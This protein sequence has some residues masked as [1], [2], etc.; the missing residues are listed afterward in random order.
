MRTI[1]GT[2][3][4]FIACTLSAQ[5]GGQHTYA[6][7]DLDNSAR[8]AALGGNLISVQDND[9]NVAYF[10]PSLLNDEMNGEIGM[11]FVDYFAGTNFGYTSYAHHFDKLGTFSGTVQFVNYGKFQETDI[12]GNVLGEF[13]ASDYVLSIGYGRKLTGPFSIGANMK[14]IFSTLERYTSFGLAFDIAGTMHLEEK[15]FTAAAVIRNAGLMLKTYVTSVREPL[16]FEVQ[17]GISYKLKHAPIRFS[18]IGENL[19]RWDLTYVDPNAQ[20]TIDPLTGEEVPVKT[21]GFGDKLMRHIVIGTEILVTEH[22][23]V[24]LGFNY[25]KRKE[26]AFDARAGMA[27]M[28]LGFG[29]RIKQFHLS[30]AWSSFNRAGGANHFSLT[31]NLHSFK[32]KES[33]DTSW[34][35][36]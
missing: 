26:L 35:T 8:V 9:L 7:L 10:N 17:L 3:F 33:A 11:N 30:Y 28:S 27:G 4:T 1:V 25:R 20:P 29:F 6:F 12:Y 36:Y 18:V 19:Q 31:S 34:M 16:P 32:R 22:I 2:I 15:R 13:R 24:R 21:P 23:N 14:S 5:T